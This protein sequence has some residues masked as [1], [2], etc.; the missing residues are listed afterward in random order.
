M[1]NKPARIPTLARHSFPPPPAQENASR[2]HFD[3]FR[4][5]PTN[6]MP[7]SCLSS[8]ILF[9]GKFEI[10]ERRMPVSD[11]LHIPP[12]IFFRD[13]LRAI[14]GYIVPAVHRLNPRPTVMVK[15]FLPNVRSPHVFAV[16]PQRMSMTAIPPRIL[17]QRVEI[18]HAPHFRPHEFFIATPIPLTW[19]GRKCPR[20]CCAWKKH[21]KNWKMR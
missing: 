7:R 21:S 10:L 14:I 18:R 16:A 2:Q 17:L 20:W 15:P 1:F 9:V 8:A 11:Q 6:R 4:V 19:T 12:R 13:I 5:H 3:T